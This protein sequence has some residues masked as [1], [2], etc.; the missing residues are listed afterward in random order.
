MTLEPGSVYLFSLLWS[1]SRPL[2]FAVCDGEG[3][4]YIYDL[5]SSLVAPSL[6]I[7]VNTDRTALQSLSWNVSEPSLLACADI[8]GRINVYNLSHK[9]TSMQSGEKR[10]LE[11]MAGMSGN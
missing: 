2:V 1:P 3:R 9:Y 7:P 11:Q 6:V 8:K 10:M 5:L 4:V